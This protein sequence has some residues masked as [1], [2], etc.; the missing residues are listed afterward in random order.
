[1]ETKQERK[2][3]DER[4]ADTACV[5]DLSFKRPTS[6]DLKNDMDGRDLDAKKE[7]PAPD[8][9]SSCHGEI[10]SLIE[11]TGKE[12][13]I[14]HEN[15]PNVNNSTAHEQQCSPGSD[16]GGAVEASACK[17]KEVAEGTHKESAECTDRDE[18]LSSAI[19]EGADT[20]DR[21]HDATSACPSPPVGL[22]ESD[23]PAL[24]ME[25]STSLCNLKVEPRS[26]SS[27]LL[28]HVRNDLPL[29]DS[30]FPDVVPKAQPDRLA[31]FTERT[32]NSTIETTR[33][34]PSCPVP[35]RP[36]SSMLPI[37]SVPKVRLRQ[38]RSEGRSS[39]THI[40]TDSTTLSVGG[41]FLDGGST[42]GEQGGMNVVDY[43]NKVIS[44]FKV[45]S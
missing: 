26:L 20:L 5:L 23:P 21:R 29:Q 14:K 16:G 8:E 28:N 19:P 12:T 32:S 43:S 22:R 17:L 10:L 18:N 27:Q 25:E 4:A 45:D 11:G 31:L 44:F 7:T 2:G 30:A 13:I 40:P 3:W 34:S 39:W 9:R 33:S 15:L 36:Y 37:L 41:Y 1:M 24:P 35:L 42:S 6:P 38:D